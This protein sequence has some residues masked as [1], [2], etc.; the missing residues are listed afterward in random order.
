MTKKALFLMAIGTLV[1]FGGLGVVIIPYTRKTVFLEFLYGTEKYW[2]QVILGIIIGTITAKAAW[3]IVELPL[4]F[5]TKKFFAELIQPFKLDMSQIIF[6]SICAGI[7]EELFFRGA[8]QPMLGVWFTAILFV[9]LH[10]YLN[11]F[12]L[13]LTIY[14]IYMVLVIGVLGLM[15]ERFGILTA[16]IAHTIIDVVLL[17]SLSTTQLEE[18]SDT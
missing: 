5:K 11:P 9:L 6:I 14:G 8:I 2:L 12:N 3:Q 18:E 13:S 4:L 10:G 7:G 17:R 16:I 15:T 1:V